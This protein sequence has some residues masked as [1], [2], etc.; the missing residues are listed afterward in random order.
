MA[1]QEDTNAPK[2]TEQRNYTP[3]TTGSGAGANYRPST[4]SGEDRP[5]P[6]RPTDD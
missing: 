5:T 6:P 2:V 4:G 3:S 1:K